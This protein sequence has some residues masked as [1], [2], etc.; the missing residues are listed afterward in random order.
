MATACL[1]ERAPCFPSRMWSISSFTNSPAAVPAD[2]PRRRSACACFTVCLSGMSDLPTPFRD[3]PPRGSDGRARRPALRRLQRSR[4]DGS[5]PGES[6]GRVPLDAVRRRP[7]ARALLVS[8]AVHAALLWLLLRL[9][10]PVTPPARAPMRISILHL[11]PRPPAAGSGHPRSTRASARGR[12]EQGGAPTEP[13]PPRT[14]EAPATSA[15]PAPRTPA[16]ADSPLQLF[17]PG[18]VARGAGPAAP[19]STGRP[20][21]T[22]TPRR[23]GPSR[24]PGCWS[25]WRPGG[26]SR[27]PSATSPS[28]STTT[29][30]TTGSRSRPGWASRRPGG[31]PKHG[32]PNAGPAVDQ[33]LARCAGRGRPI[34][35]RARARR[36]DARHRTSRT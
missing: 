21:R 22:R 2:L 1:L 4:S 14:A 29:S 12:P 15:A 13:T 19:G 30:R 32:D 3:C 24:E 35:A 36:A 20:D 6:A 9:A 34:E 25:G 11:P 23:A 26:G 31:G 28:A 7:Y 5:S 18:A 33:R 8:I 17:P 16:P 10:G 27:S